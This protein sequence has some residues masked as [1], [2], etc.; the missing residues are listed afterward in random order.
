MPLDKYFGGH[1][2]SVMSKMKK[3]YGE[4]KG[5]DVFYATKNKMKSKKKKDALA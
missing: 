2:K 4:E 3:K 1:G 5:E